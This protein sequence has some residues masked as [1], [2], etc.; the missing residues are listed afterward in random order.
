M[1]KDLDRVQRAQNLASA[2]TDLKRLGVDFFPRLTS[3][4]PNYYIRSQHSWQDGAK[5]K[6]TGL[7]SKDP[8]SLQ[9]VV[10]LCMALHK[11]PTLLNK[12]T[13]KAET[14]PFSA[15]GALCMKLEQH[16]RDNLRVNVEGH[17]DYTRHLSELRAH[18]GPV[19]A[20]KIQAWAESDPKNSR[21]RSRK[22]TTVRSLISIGVQ[23]D[24]LWWTKLQGESH[25]NGFREINPRD[26]PSDG[27]IQQFVDSIRHP[28]WRQVFGLM[29]VF[30]LRSSEPFCLESP[31][32][33]DGWI[34]I[35]KDS[36]TGYRV[37][38]PRRPD[39]LDR[40]NLW[41]LDLPKCNA[42]WTVRRKGSKTCD[43]FRRHS[44]GAKWRKPT[45]YSLRHAYAGRIYTS[46]EFDHLMPHTTA[47]YM[48]HSEKIHR[49]YYQRW[50]D[51][52]ELK[53]KAKREAR[54]G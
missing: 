29:A 4:S 52:K 37:V 51:K 7:S 10:D 48:G 31:T 6:S 42:E 5:Y 39:W 20:A 36:K 21:H 40:W 28:Q 15:W 26:I 45:P 49:E 38:M 53:Q 1:D 14:N 24:S 8:S 17:T 34:E 3:Q 32:D 43:Y 44:E 41:E 16:L 12:Q 46:K 22:L 23:V 54:G 33:N 27:L 9:K 11:D 13:K 19:T 25:F 18:T 50:I 30:G 35:S 47:R 2:V